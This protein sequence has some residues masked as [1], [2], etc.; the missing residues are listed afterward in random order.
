[1]EEGDGVSAATRGSSGS[2]ASLA[3]EFLLQEQVQRSET[4]R[5]DISE[6]LRKMKKV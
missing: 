1:M 6:V 4:L 5:N 3:F 2:V